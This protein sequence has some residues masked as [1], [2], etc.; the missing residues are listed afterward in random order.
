MNNFENFSMNSASNFD[1][2]AKENTT[3]ID[4]TNVEKQT[5]VKESHPSIFMNFFGKEAKGVSNGLSKSKKFP[6]YL[7]PNQKQN[8]IDVPIS[9]PSVVLKNYAC[10]AL[11]G[12]QEVSAFSLAFFSKQNIQAIQNLLKYNVFIASDRKYKI[13]D[14]NE[15]E[16]KI[17]MRGIYLQYSQVPEHR[18]D[19]PAAI[20][21]L[22]VI[23]VEQILPDLLSNIVQYVYY[24]RDSTS[25]LKPLE[26]PQ[27]VSSAGTK[28]NKSV[29]DILFGT[30]IAEY[31]S[32]FFK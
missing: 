17:I 27:N 10:E 25:P 20:Q 13:G 4:F 26:N 24:L 22:N 14:Q 12:I 16:L 29:S 23:I 2:G 3:G 1:W 6:V 31:N 9:E 18:K 32:Q 5:S 8:F 30:T 21:N 15:S 28:I 7:L 11:I 19:Y